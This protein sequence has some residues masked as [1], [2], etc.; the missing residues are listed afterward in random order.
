MPAALVAIFAALIPHLPDLVL[1]AETLFNDVAT[2][3]GGAE[4]VAKAA[5][6]L[7]ALA[8]TAGTVA[9][10]AAPAPAAPATPTA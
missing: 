6:A 7:S 5:T 3:D 4:K 8:A 9:A 1:E 10:A 2:G